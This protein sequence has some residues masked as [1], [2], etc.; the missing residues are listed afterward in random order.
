MADIDTSYLDEDT[1]SIKAARP[2]LLETTQRVNQLST[3]TGATIVGWSQNGAGATTRFLQDKVRDLVSV[4]DFGAIGDGVADDT[5]A[6]QT[7]VTSCAGRILELPAGTYIVSSAINLVSNTT[8]A[9]VGTI[10]LKDN[11]SP[12]P[13]D[14]LRCNTATNIDISDITIDANRQNNVDHG[15]PDVNGNQLN[16]WQGTLLAAIDFAYVTGF[17]ISNV[18]V[19]E[20]WG[21]GIWL[22]DCQDGVVNNNTVKN[23]RITGIAVRNNTANAATIKTVRVVN[24]H[25]EGG[26]VGVHFIFGAYDSVCNGNICIG[27]KDSARFPAYA[28]SGTYPNVYPSTGGFKAYGVSG[29]VSPAMVG[30]GAG[31]EA[32]GVFTDPSGTANTAIS[33]TGN[34]C[35]ANAVGIRLEETSNKFAVSG[36]TCRGNDAYGILLFSAYFNTLSG[37]T[38]TNNGLDGIRL[39]KVTGK[40]QASNNTVTSNVCTENQRYGVIVVGSQG[41]I[42]TNNIISGNGLNTSNTESGAIGL[43]LVDGIAASSGIISGNTFGNYFGTDKYGI[44]SNS[45]SN[46][47]N[48]VTNNQFSNSYVTSK[49]TLVLANNFVSRNVGLKTDAKGAAT[50]LAGNTFIDFAHGLDGAPAITSIQVTPTG[51]TG[52]AKWWIQSS[53]ATN[54]RIQINAVQGTALNFVWNVIP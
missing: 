5:L 12:K 33:I 31:I 46:A 14:I 34:V 10:K 37:N 28:Y 30:D 41:N 38:C 35:S 50:I 2:A 20:C 26:I 7:A 36:N 18:T 47:A 13:A 6:I 53:D 15:T 44:Y 29:Y 40:P 4:K 24:N 43:Y 48:I 21:S 23:H 22:T 11:C 39:E 42:I 54:I 49:T 52:T 1:D 16:S 32:T 27:N 25:V 8:I 9:G 45:A 51:D 19:K 17:S 3:P